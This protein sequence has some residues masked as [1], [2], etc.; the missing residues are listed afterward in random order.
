MAIFI[1]CL[2]AL[3]NVFD[4]LRLTVRVLNISVVLW[5]TSLPSLHSTTLLPRMLRGTLLHR[6]RL[7]L[8][9][10]CST[11]SIIVLLKLFSPRHN[12]RYALTVRHCLAYH[13]HQFRYSQFIWCQRRLARFVNYPRRRPQELCLA[14]V[15][16]KCVVAIYNK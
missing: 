3:S 2:Y 10:L 5:S 6:L 14:H 15:R 1:Q 16:H 9:T 13:D 8:F 7:I 12:Y 11:I 4:V